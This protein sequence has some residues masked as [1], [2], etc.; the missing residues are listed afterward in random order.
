MVSVFEFKETILLF[1]DPDSDILE[2]DF[3]SLAMVLKGDP[4]F[5]GGILFIMI[6]KLG[7]DHAID[8]LNN[9][10][11]FGYD[12]QVIPAIFLVG[13]LHFVGIRHFLD[14]SSPVSS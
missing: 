10:R 13:G 7:K 3:G 12:H 4:S 11:S 5:G 14:A 8:L 6:R 9:R 1:I 2:L